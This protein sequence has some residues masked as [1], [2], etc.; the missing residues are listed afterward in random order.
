[1]QNPKNM[2]RDTALVHAGRKP[3]DYHGVVNPPL[4]RTSTILYPNLAAYED[5]NHRYRYGRLGNPLSDSFE[6]AIADL[7]GGFDAISCQS[8]MSAITTALLSFLKTGDHLLVADTC[9]PPV[10]DFCRNILARMGVETEYYDPMAGIEIESL[11]RPNTAVIYMES[12]GSGTF[13]VM[14][15][16][17]VARLARNKGVVTIID[18]TW[19]AGILFNPIKHGVNVCLQSAT[20]YIGGHSDINLG[21][22]VAADE[23]TFARLRQMSWDLGVCAAAEDLNL[24]LRG[25]RTLTT[26]MKQNAANAQA[27]MDWM[28]GRPEIQ[29]LYHPSLP[30]HKGHDIWKR[31][32]TG[33]NGIFS[34]LLK[35]APREAVHSF[36]DALTLIPIGSSW[37][38]Y[39]SLLQPQYPAK[40][41]SAVPWTENGAL[42]RFQI[43]F[44]DPADL[45]AN[46]EQALK[47]FNSNA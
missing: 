3:E 47:I 18:N 40:I 34:F 46:I 45:I 19:S 16:P 23:E 24:A 10:R 22:I 28:A 29:K 6:R 15:V 25:L 13:E 1:M 33:A 27:V 5:K 38:G 37:G 43:G 36:V 20:K 42:L 44:E 9:Y 30:G 4:V 17:A 41:R 39:E 31:D 8:G 12:P 2:R 7:E 26:R 32:F 35:P 21:V 11:I 14:D